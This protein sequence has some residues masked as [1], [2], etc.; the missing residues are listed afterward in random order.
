MLG[1]AIF[2]LYIGLGL[3]RRVDDFG[4]RVEEFEGRRVKE[5][6]AAE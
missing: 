2:A 5:S 6:E 1:G 4:H 3:G